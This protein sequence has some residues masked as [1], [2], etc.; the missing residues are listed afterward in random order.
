MPP[1]TAVGQETSSGT[2]S[3]PE[4]EIEVTALPPIF[5]VGDRAD[6]ARLVSLL[7]GRDG[8]SF[9]PQS[10]LLTDLAG[11]AKRN[12]PDLCRYGYPEQYWLRRVAGFFD[13]LQAEYAAS[14]R[15]TRWGATV[16]PSALALVDRLFP[17]C[18]VVWV[19]PE[20]RPPWA[21]RAAAALGPHRCYDL[22]ADELALR[23]DA[24]VAGVLRFLDPLVEAPR[25]P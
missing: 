2:P 3:R 22:R 17:R 10:S 23:P 19:V 5:V 9:A 14:R 6:R 15:L 4:L 7:D 18:K 12:L 25:R 1:E 16:D 11:A 8:I 21:G 24:A 20:R 13:S